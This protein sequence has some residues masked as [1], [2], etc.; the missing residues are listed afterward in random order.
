MSAPTI[1]LL[2]GMGV[3]STAPFLDLVI[4]ECQRQYGARYE[5]DYPPMMIYSLPVP[6]YPDRP[7][8]QGAFRDAV[9]AGLRR[10][11]DTGPDFIAI[12]CNS[13]HVFFD[14]LAAVARVP[15][16]NLV[17]QAVTALPA[18]AGTVALL[19]TRYTRD[20]RIYQN[21]LG[22]SGRPVAADDDL[23]KELDGLLAELRA[24]SDL[25]EPRSRWRGI[26]Q[27]VRDR[28]AD[29]ALLACTDL[30]VL[31]G[32]GDAGLVPVVDGTRALAAAVVDRWA[33]A[34]GRLA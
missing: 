21:R 29:A 6:F 15:L 20:S 33:R 5:P 31:C 7:V 9:L 16:L 3:R 25:E 13:A 22:A 24:T 10:L 27:T 8:D 34:T 23:Q 1:G 12:P 19:A 32:P 28:G 26:L 2:A 4:D 30:N 11:Q 18:G 17:D 14:D